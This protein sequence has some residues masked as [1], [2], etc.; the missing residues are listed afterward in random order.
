MLSLFLLFPYYLLLEKGMAIHLNKIKSPSLKDALCQVWLKL[1]Q[2]FWG[3]RF[4]KFVNVFLL[5]CYYLPFGKAMALHLNKIKFPLLKD[6]F[7]RVWL[8]LVLWF[9]RR[10]FLMFVNVF[11]LFCY[12]LSL[13]KEVALHLNKLESISYKDALCQ[14][15]LQI[16]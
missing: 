9:W 10:R 16:S 6:A 12:F 14:V 3:R 2:W 4:L 1:V 7:C 5:F 11:S 13:E 15:W 8:K